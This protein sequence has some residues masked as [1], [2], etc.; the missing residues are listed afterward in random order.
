MSKSNVRMDENLRRRR[1]KV[2]EINQSRN[3][4]GIF[5]HLFPQLL[6]DEDRF[7]KFLRMRI[8][9]FF[10]I[11]EKIRPDLE[12]DWCNIH[13]QPILPEEQLALTIW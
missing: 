1:N 8:E 10:Y 2:H 12:K 11:L 3:T 13:N 4:Y 6:E 7:I 5:H 9:T